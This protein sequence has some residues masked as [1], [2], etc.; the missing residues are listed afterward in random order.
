MQLKNRVTRLETAFSARRNFSDAQVDGIFL[1]VGAADIP[2][3]RSAE[4]KVLEADESFGWARQF[5]ASREKQIAKFS[6]QDLADRRK[7]S[8]KVFKDHPAEWWSYAIRN[9]FIDAWQRRFP[10][11]LCPLPKVDWSEKPAQKP[12]AIAQ[13]FTGLSH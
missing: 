7:A 2:D 6:E 8:E 12:H 3:S 9:R 5:F 10:A 4:R 13:K 1:F 11:V